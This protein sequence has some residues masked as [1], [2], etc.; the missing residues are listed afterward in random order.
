MSRWIPIAAAA[1]AAAACA[2][3]PWYDPSR[4]HRAADGFRNNYPHAEKGGFWAW[5]WE[6]WRLGLPADAFF[7]MRHGETRRLERR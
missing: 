5:Q 1:L 4:P 2:A 3:S 7:T 6:R